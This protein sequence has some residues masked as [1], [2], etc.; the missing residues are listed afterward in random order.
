MFVDVNPSLK[1]S[2]LCPAQTTPITKQY[3]QYVQYTPNVIK[4]PLEKISTR[5]YQG[6]GPVITKAGNHSLFTF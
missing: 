3:E 4:P 2:G 1:N 6:P 5:G